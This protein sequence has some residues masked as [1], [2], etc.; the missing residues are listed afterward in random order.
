MH[1]MLIEFVT[2]QQIYIVRTRM[3]RWIVLQITDLITEIH[4]SKG[5]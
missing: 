3:I 5:M 4:L 2:H 1:D